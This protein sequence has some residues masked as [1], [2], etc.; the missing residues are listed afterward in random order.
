M[1]IP[2]RLTPDKVLIVAQ[3]FYKTLSA[4]HERRTLQVVPDAGANYY[5]D[6]YW[7]VTNPEELELQIQDSSAR[8]FRI[9]NKRAD[10]VIVQREAERAEKRRPLS[11]AE[12][13][14]QAQKIRALFDTRGSGWIPAKQYRSEPNPLASRWNVSW[15]RTYKN[16]VFRNQSAIV[17]L[18]P[19]TG[20]LISALLDRWTQLPVN[21]R[22]NVDKVQAREI[23]QSWVKQYRFSNNEVIVSQKRIVHRTL[24]DKNQHLVPELSGSY[25]AWEMGAVPIAVD[26]QTGE[27]FRQEAPFRQQ[28]IGGRFAERG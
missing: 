9:F 22:E 5:N 28:T 4:P 18:D 21:F 6:P 14:K 20:E 11:E 26:C 1:K 10:Q 19:L 12:L 16:L 27:V 3:A 23:A 17:T 8:V 25:V 13:E 24:L 2:M 7:S 15:V